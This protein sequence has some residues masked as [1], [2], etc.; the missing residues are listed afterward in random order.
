MQIRCICG[1]Y[2]NKSEERCQSC[3]REF[4]FFLA[5]ANQDKY[6]WELLTQLKGV[7]WGE[8]T[9]TVK[10]GEPVMISERR[11]TKLEKGIGS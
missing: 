2:A 8:V 10:A 3:G 4:Y 6:L 11:D 5:L 7:V 9:V 1:D